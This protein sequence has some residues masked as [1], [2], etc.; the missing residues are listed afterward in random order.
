MNGKKYILY[1]F[2]LMRTLAI[3]NRAE[4]NPGEKLMENIL[5]VI[6]KEKKLFRF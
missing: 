1:S 6:R 2:H 3:E 4:K 5:S